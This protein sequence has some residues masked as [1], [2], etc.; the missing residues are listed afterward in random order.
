[1]SQ[2]IIKLT[3]LLKEIIKEV[4]DLQNIQP[5]PYDLKKGTFA[6]PYKGREYRGK[7]TFTFLNEKGLSVF[8]LPPIVDLSKIK[9]GYNIGYSIEGVGSQF[10]RGDV[11]LLFTILKTVSILVAEFI[12][13]HPDS[14]YLVF[15]EDKA[16]IGMA[17]PQKLALYQQILARNLPEGFR[18]GEA[19]ILKDIPG[20]FICKIK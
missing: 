7:V 17:D 11:K 10:I 4:G 20:L 15:G 16:G 12:K 8:E 6:V 18:I 13:E 9:T 1:M 5:L 14:L 3:Q 2:N 19:S